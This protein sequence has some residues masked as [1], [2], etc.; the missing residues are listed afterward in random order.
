ML[1]LSEVMRY[2][3]EPPEVIRCVL[4]CMLEVVKGVRRVLELLEVVLCVLERALCAGA[5][6]VCYGVLESTSQ[7]LASTLREVLIAQAV[8]S[9]L[10]PSFQVS[11]FHYAGSATSKGQFFIYKPFTFYLQ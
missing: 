11:L 7:H 4:L 2:M 3:L 10:F 1:E 8:D 9:F 5:C 6:S